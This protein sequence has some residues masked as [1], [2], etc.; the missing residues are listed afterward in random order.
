V[1]RKEIRTS[2]AE[3]KERINVGYTEIILSVLII[4]LILWKGKSLKWNM[5]NS[6]GKLPVMKT[7]YFWMALVPLAAKML[8]NVN[9][10]KIP[11]FDGSITIHLTLP[12]SWKILFYSSL[13]FAIANTLY[14]ILCPPLIKIYKDFKD[15]VDRGGSQEE[16]KIAFMKASSKWSDIIVK[17]FIAKYDIKPI[18]DVEKSIGN[19]QE[20]GEYGFVSEDLKMF[21]PSNWYKYILYHMKIAPDKVSDAFHFVSS[22]LDNA[23]NIG[24]YITLSF[25]LIGF[26]LLFTLIKQ[27]F[28]FVF[29]QSF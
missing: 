19:A 29:N 22:I 20:R 7:S 10:I 2:C 15:F 8:S 23:K 16:L 12:F 18:E 27:N 6:I 14:I 17:D 28:L 25:Y 4:V 1:A 26:V 13:S 3:L 24:F 11:M 9:H 5:I 21:L